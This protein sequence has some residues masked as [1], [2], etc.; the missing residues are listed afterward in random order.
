M[1]RL[2]Q[3]I[4]AL[5]VAASLGA[6]LTAYAAADA[7]ADDAAGGAVMRPHWH[8]GGGELGE[9]G[10]LLH[11]LNLGADQKAKIHALMAGQRSE[12]E[13][14]HQSMK[15][16]RQALAATSPD[17]A[18]YADLLAQAQK[19]AAQ[20]I[21]LVGSMWK[22][23]YDTVLTDEQRKAI[24]DIVAAAEAQRESRMQ[25]WKAQHAAPEV[26]APQ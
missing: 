1:I 25:A 17:D 5:C 3:I 24:P 16:N 2:R 15:A 14:L 6:G 12:F 23:V 7:A 26:P 11:R 22:Q 9:M 20:R 4:P 18:G 8:R 13:S 21:T 19:N 10:F